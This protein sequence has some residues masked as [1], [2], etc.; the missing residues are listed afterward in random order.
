MRGG[1]PK[2]TRL[3]LL[4]GNPGKRPFNMNEPKLD[5]EITE[6]PSA[7]GPIAQ[8]EWQRLSVDLN[9][10]RILSQL[11]RAALAAYCGAY[12]L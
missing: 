6:C 10:L 7:L 3:K 9:K 1:R 5:A 4:T 2:P 11:D 12:S 8:K